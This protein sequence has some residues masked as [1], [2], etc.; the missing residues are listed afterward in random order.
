MSGAESYPETGQS[1]KRNSSF[2]PTDLTDWR[3]LHKTQLQAALGGVGNYYKFK[4]TIL[5]SEHEP[6]VLDSFDY[7]LD[8]PQHYEVQKQTALWQHDGFSPVEQSWLQE[9]YDKWFGSNTAA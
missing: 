9:R 8:E 2:E 5:P 7:F 4:I 3:Q 6:I 1:I